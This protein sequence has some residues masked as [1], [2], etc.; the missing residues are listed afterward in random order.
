M[1]SRRERLC[2]WLGLCCS[3]G[4]LWPVMD[5]LRRDGHGSKKW[6]RTE[7]NHPIH[8][9]TGA[10]HMYHESHVCILH[11]LYYSW[12]EAITIWL[13]KSLWVDPDLLHTLQIVVLLHC[14]HLSKR[15]LNAANEFC[16]LEQQYTCARGDCQRT[17][18]DGIGSHWINFTE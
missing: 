3:K 5:N 2:W 4:V 6:W 13:R 14:P 9:D 18:S 17:Q 15:D 16:M 8:Q 7:A 1:G 10:V 12:L 11:V